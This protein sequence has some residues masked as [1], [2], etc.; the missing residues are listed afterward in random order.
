MMSATYIAGY[1]IGMLVAGVGAVLAGYFGTEMGHYRYQAW[2]WTYA[3]MAATMLI[4]VRTTLLIAEPARRHSDAAN[5]ALH[6][7]MCGSSCVSAGGEQL[8][9][10]FFHHHDVLIDGCRAPGAA[11]H[12]HVVGFVVEAPAPG[13]GRC[14]PPGASL[15]WR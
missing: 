4:G 10:R 9:R 11:G 5:M 6:G 8:Y 7:S 3:I 2:R 1:R 13:C 12:E 14:S 15:A